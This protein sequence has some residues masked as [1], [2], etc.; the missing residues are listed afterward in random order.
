[1]ILYDSPNTDWDKAMEILA[2]KENIRNAKTAYQIIYRSVKKALD[3]NDK[4]F[5]KFN[6]ILPPSF[7]YTPTTKNFVEC[8]AR[9]LHKVDNQKEKCLKATY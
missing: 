9:Y 2:V 5:T 3:R 6:N 4:N 1:M 7:I 8:M